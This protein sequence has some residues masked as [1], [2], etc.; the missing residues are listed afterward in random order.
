MAD[1]INP[2]TIESLLAHLD[3]QEII[4]FTQRFVQIPSVNGDEREA[5]AFVAETCQGAGLQV[6]VRDVHDGRPNVL[7]VWP[8][9][10]ETVGLLLHG[11]TDTVPFLNMRDPTSG[12]IED[13]YIWGRG[14]VDQKGGLAASVMAV[15]A[16]ARSGVRLEKGV[17]VAA[18]IDEE[19]E[20]RGSMALVDDG[21]QADCAIVTEPSDLHLLVAHKGTAPIRIRFAGVLAHGSNPW[22]G[23]NAVEMASRT[24]TALKELELKSVEVPGIGTMRAS[25]NVGLIE[26][27]TAYNN[28]ADSCTLWLDRRMV[29]GETQAMAVAEVEEVLSRLAAEDPTFK[30]AAEIARPDWKWDRIQERG[31]NPSLTPPHSPV[32]Q[33]VAAA[34]QTETGESIEVGYTHGYNDGDFLV[35]DLGIPTV[36]YGPGEGF[37]S[38]TVEEQLRIDHLLT[39]ARVYLRTSLMM[40]GGT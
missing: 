23:V 15:L 26:G 9:E 32:A 16:L 35:N 14:S 12:Q 10:S 38:H 6:S 4:E 28:V 18:V 13:S 25:F 11:H 8:G 17:A 22:V 37:R 5:A 31:L 40:S 21:L 36:N 20:H 34:H 30:A 33:A 7:A 19:S 1:T 39:A 2:S 27:G 29:P 24:V 3:D